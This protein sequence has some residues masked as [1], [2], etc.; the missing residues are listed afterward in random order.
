MSLALVAMSHS[1]LIDHVEP[2]PGVTEELVGVFDRT[3]DFVREIDPELIITFAPDHYNGFFYDLMPTCCIG[4]AAYGI[5]DYGSATGDLPVPTELAA[6]LAAA[7]LADGVDVAVSHRMALDHGAVQPL[8][9]LFGGI[10]GV[11]VIPVFVNGVAPPFSPMQRIRLL[12]EA[13]GR[14]ADARPERILLIA[15]GGLSHDPPVPQWATANDQQR[16]ML[17]A[18]R[19]PTPE[20]RAARQQRVIDAAADFA[21]GRASILDLNPDWDLQFMERCAAGDPVVFDSYDPDMMTTEAGNSSHEVRAWVAAVSALAAAGAYRVTDR[22]Y[23][24]L[25]EFIAGFGVLTARTS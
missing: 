5:G 23:R 17:L 13:I 8:E 10:E 24:A 15:S 6:S 20:A 25:P 2:S 18:G 11:P 16:A 3:R 9:T 1:P 14:W 19:N 21:A 4:T 22:Y 12:G 7:V